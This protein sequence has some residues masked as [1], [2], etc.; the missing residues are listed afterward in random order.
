MA[1]MASVGYSVAEFVDGDEAVVIRKEDWD[2]LVAWSNTV[3][4]EDRPDF[5][6]LPIS[7]TIPEDFFPVADS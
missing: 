4:N 6:I 2:K 1:S 7:F 5:D 3:P